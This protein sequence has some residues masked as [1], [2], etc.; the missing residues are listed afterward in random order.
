MISEPETWTRRVNL[1]GIPIINT[2]KQW[3]PF[4]FVLG[5]A[6]FSVKGLMPDIF[7]SLRAIMNFT[8]ILTEPP[9]EEWGVHRKHEN[10]TFYWSGMVG[11]L[12]RRDVDICIAGLT[13]NVARQTAI[14]FTVGVIADPMSVVIGTEGQGKRDINTMAYLSVF[15]LKTWC[16]MLVI[17]LTTFFCFALFLQQ[18]LLRDGRNPVI[19]FFH[20]LVFFLRSLIQVAVGSLASS[21]SLSFKVIFLS[22]AW[23]C[24]FAFQGY[25]GDLTAV[26]TARPPKVTIKSFQDLIDNNFELYLSKGTISETFFEEAP[27]DSAMARIYKEKTTMTTYDKKIAHLQKMEILTSVPRSAL[28]ANVYQFRNETARARPLMDFQEMTKGVLGFG[29]QKDSEFK[30]AFNYYIVKLRELGILDE[31]FARWIKENMPDD[32]SERIFVED[33]S[34]LGYDNLF[35]PAMVLL[36]GFIGG[37]VVVLYEAATIRPKISN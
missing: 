22:C 34:V 24:F 27:E 8:V 2:V 31:I 15:S 6:Q 37:V 14:D 9:D 29:L 7:D 11:Q 36:A 28:Y 17:T 26:M 23:V 4:T 20:G 19:S 16:A 35:F 18:P 5:D 33:A 25:V 21:H 12:S 10:G 13:V 1:N 3:A 32:M 30:P